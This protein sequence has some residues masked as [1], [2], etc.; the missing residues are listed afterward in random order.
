[1]TEELRQ[2]IRDSAHR[3]RSR[4]TYIL[5]CA[6]TLKLDLRGNLSS[7]QLAEFQQLDSVVEETSGVAGLTQTIGTR[8]KRSADYA[9]TTDRLFH[10]RR[11]RRVLSARALIQR[12]SLST[13]STAF[14]AGTR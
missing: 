4:L 1:M 14:R 10:K 6:H 7:A 13:T 12:R 11:Q 3:L 8:V 5:L 2:L 9:R